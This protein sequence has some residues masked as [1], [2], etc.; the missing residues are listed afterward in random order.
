LFFDEVGALLSV[1]HDLHIGVRVPSKQVT[2]LF[3]EKI[4]EEED[5]E[6]D[7]KSWR[8]MKIKEGIVKVQENS[9]LC[10]KD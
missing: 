5:E 10:V 2:H 3:K 9:T 4:E 1:K 6:D 7:M 8:D